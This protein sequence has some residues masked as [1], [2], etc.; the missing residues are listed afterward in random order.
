MQHDD[1]TESNAY[2]MY[3]CVLSYC[4]LLQDSDDYDD[5]GDEIQNVGAPGAAAAV[6]LNPMVVEHQ[7][8]AW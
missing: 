1:A 7:H 8:L 5:D 3:G 4:H 2:L 6:I